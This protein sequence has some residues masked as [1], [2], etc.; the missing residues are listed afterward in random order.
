MMMVVVGVIDCLVSLFLRHVDS[1]ATV[2][3]TQTIA[4]SAL[5]ALAYNNHKVST[6]ARTHT[7]THT[8]T[9]TQTN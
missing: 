1:S 9:V 8:H 7:H 3:Q 2:G 5:L 4:C 6:H